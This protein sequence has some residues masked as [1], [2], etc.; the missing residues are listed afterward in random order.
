MSSVSRPPRVVVDTNLFVSGLIVKRGL[1]HRLLSHWR[2]GSFTLLISE[3][4]R[5]EIQIVL[6]RP[7]IVERY[8]ITPEERA[9]LLWLIDA[10]AVRV[11]SH[12]PLPLTVRDAKDEIILASALGGR[13]DFL[14]T[15][16]ED[17]LV[18]SGSAEIGPLRILR[19]REL[20]ELLETSS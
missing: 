4:Q 9:E 5:E 11:G 7:V 18:L 12:Q 20:V 17:L 13:A 3:E 10:I 15:G 6:H 16:D 1:P 19:A 2:H 8:G 14:V